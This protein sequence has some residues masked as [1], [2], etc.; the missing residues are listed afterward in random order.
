M[1]ERVHRES[2][3]SRDGEMGTDERITISTSRQILKLFCLS[4]IFRRCSL[5]P[6]ALSAQVSKKRETWGTRQERLG[7]E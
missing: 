1:S 3:N 6:A 7:K 4:P 2:G 5:V